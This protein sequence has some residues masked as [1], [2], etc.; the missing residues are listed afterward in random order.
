VTAFW[1]NLSLGTAGGILFYFTGMM[2]IE[3]LLTVPADLKPEIETAFPWVACV[4]PLALVSG[5]SVT[6]LIRQF[7]ASADQ[8]MIGSVLGVTAVA[9]Y[10]VPMSLVVRRQLLA[11]PCRERYF[12]D[13][14]DLLGMRLTD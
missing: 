2:F 6:N 1:L 4:L 10:S 8:L 9:H 5:T 12:R 7:L 13:C 11:R 3:H 14:R